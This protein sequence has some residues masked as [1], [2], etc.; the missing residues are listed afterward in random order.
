M[1]LNSLVVGARPVARHSHWGMIPSLVLQRGTSIEL[2]ASLTRTILSA[3]GARTILDVATLQSLWSGCGAVAR[4]TL[5]GAP[6]SSV[7][8]KQIAVPPA[9]D[10]PRGWQGD[11]S[12]QRK[13]RSY[14]VELDWYRRWQPRC[15]EYSRVPRCFWAEGDGDNALLVLED[16]DA[17]GFDARLARADCDQVQSCLRW[18]AAFHG[19]FI[20]ARPDGLW[21]EGCYWHLATRRDEW[22]AMTDEPLQR[23]A[24]ALDARLGDCRFKTLVHGDA[25]LANFCFSGDFRRV[26]AVDFQYVGGGCGIRD[27]AYLLGSALDVEQ[28]FAW[29]DTLLDHYFDALQQAIARRHSVGE[30]SVCGDAVVAEWRGLFDIAWADFSRFLQGWSPS[31][32]KLNDYS[33]HQVRLALSKIGATQ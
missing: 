27:V 17:G 30:M 32:A 19:H 26:A 23:A 28:C 4:V 1:A 24:A 18:L 10:H 8:I 15:S 20:G 6:V 2:S 22:R 21:P 12:R 29:Q 9:L 14:R 11:A 16:L 13:L 25:K 3:T 31:H 5:A 33:D 7:V